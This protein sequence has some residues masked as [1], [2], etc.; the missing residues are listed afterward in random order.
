MSTKMTG[1]ITNDGSL[2]CITIIQH[3]VYNAFWRNSALQ[4]ML[5]DVNSPYKHSTFMVIAPW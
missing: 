1:V 4:A 2:E 5:Q 3:I